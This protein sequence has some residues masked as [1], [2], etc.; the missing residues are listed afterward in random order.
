MFRFYSILFF[1]LFSTFFATGAIVQTDYYFKQLSLDEGLSQST[2]RCV[3]KDSHGYLWIGTRSGLNRYDTYELN[4]YRNTLKTPNLLPNNLIN[5]LTEDK[6][7]LIWIATELGTSTYDYRSEKI[8]EVLIDNKPLRLKSFFDNGQSL[9]LGGAGGLY[10][11]N[12]EQK[13][14]KELAFEGKEKF[15]DNIIFV[16]KWDEHN[17]LLGT[18]WAGL[19]MYD[20]ENKTV[21]RASF[22]TM[23]DIISYHLDKDGI[24]WLSPYGKGLLGYNSSRK[25]VG[26]LNTCNGLINNDIV[27]DIESKGN[28]I[29]IATDG[30]GMSIYNKLH[31]TINRLEYIAGN[32]YSFPANSIFTIYKDQEENIWAGTIRSGL[33]G[34]KEVSIRTFKD[35]PPNYHSG[36]SD[37]TVLQLIQDENN[38]WIGTDGG[39]VNRFDSKTNTF[40][41]YPST[42]KMKIVSLAEF[43]NQHLIISDFV[44]GIYLFNKNEGRL[45]PLR[46]ADYKLKEES[47]QKGISINV[48]SLNN[49]IYIF[50]DQVY[51]FQKG[52]KI[53]STIENNTIKSKHS[54]LQRVSKDKKTIYIVN[55]SQILAIDVEKNSIESLFKASP[56]FVINTIAEGEQNDLWIG[57]DKGLMHLSLDSK[58]CRN[59]DTYLF[60]EVSS[61][62]MDAKGKLWIGAKDRLYAYSPDTK[63]MTIFGESDGVSSNEYLSKPTLLGRDSTIYMGGVNGLLA[64]SK[65][66][67]W[68]EDDAPILA[69]SKLKVDG[70][71][72]SIGELGNKIEIPWNHNTMSFRII[73]KDKDFFRERAY[74]YTLMGKETLVIDSREK[75][76]ILNSLPVGSYNLKTSYS[77]RDGEWAD[78]QDIVSFTV[79]PPWWRTTWFIMLSIALFIAIITFLIRFLLQQ[80]EQ[81]IE[82]QKRE[83]EK[84]AYEEKIRFL[85]NIS[86]ELRTPLTLIYAPLKRLLKTI[87]AESDNPFDKQLKQILKQASN[88]RNI[89]NMVLDIRRMEIQGDTLNL[90]EYDVKQWVNEVVENFVG[91]LESN[92][93]KLSIIIDSDIS[94]TRF[95]K[96]KS[97]IILSNLLMNALKYSDKKTNITIKIESSQD[98]LKI[99]VIDQGI[100]LSHLDIEKLFT[101]FYK[102]NTTSGGSGI[103]LSYSKQLV[104]LQGGKIGAE[105]NAD[106]G[107]CF[108]FT[109]PLVPK[110]AN[111][112]QLIDESEIFQNTI[113]TEAYTLELDDRHSDLSNYTLLVVE[114]SIDL[115]EFM[116]ESLSPLFKDIYVCNDGLEALELIKNKQ[117]NI[118]VSDVM[119]PNMDGF[120]LCK[121]IKQDID[122]SHIP[123]V[124]L[125]AR[126]DK[127]SR[128]IGYKLGADAY[129][130]KPFEMEDL[131][132][133]I[134]NQIETRE[135][136]KQRYLTT[137]LIIDPLKNTFSN[138]DENF[139]LKLNKLIEDNFSNPDLNVDFV[140]NHM[141]MSRASLY[142]KFNAIIGI[143]VNDYIV[144]YKIEHAANLLLTTDDPIGEIAFVLGFSNQ[145]YFS[146]VFKDIKGQ[147]P[148]MYRISKNN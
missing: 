114:D 35:A 89:I 18:R 75:E 86:H 141:A 60:D 143:G 73:T 74:K 36:L 97:D 130:S 64:I 139:I 17:Y 9:L 70:V 84:E 103:G 104:N 69:L 88:M 95:D 112:K 110:N 47:F 122:I 3:L 128:S 67:S 126:I 39:G 6:N 41:H 109:L 87:Q 100:G 129:I 78:A 7:G 93:I 33:I 146:T 145:R 140:S 117:P 125:T 24:L 56:N 14:I 135:N 37:R 52:S 94:S 58:A 62:I 119:M 124:L 105:N 102:G 59:I 43:D 85:I 28:D 13:D 32:P 148:S 53:V 133:I 80:K 31:K 115:Q 108:W 8:S 118:V 29:W 34:I 1:L 38:I 46:L 134:K 106:K 21:S 11:Y 76:I 127:D 2:V 81:K 40:K 15:Y 61:L 98:Y 16:N 107:A 68:Q 92:E 138:S 45:I 82:K 42:N 50:S 90:L 79:Y 91:E 65:N 120:E 25:L 49:R 44:K 51:S 27:L 132:A 23:K 113:N 12:Y 5:A 19:W 123:V 116:Q 144:N 131:V 48:L 10:E 63:K 72:M 57:T 55:P 137:N 111:S 54:F 96:E 77:T 4:V 136:I 99:S 142:N 30:G 71:D 66:I 22:S 20:R 26:E 101:R 147:T 83:Y 121:R